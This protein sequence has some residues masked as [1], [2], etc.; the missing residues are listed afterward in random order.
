MGKIFDWIDNKFSIKQHHKKLFYRAL[1]DNVNYFYC[2]GGIA[3]TLYVS[4]LFTG[5]L[6]SV[7]YV[8]SEEEAF[9]SIVKITK[10]VRLGWFI[11]SLHKWGANLLIFFVILHTIRVI[12]HR[13]YKHPR[14]LNWVIGVFILI[15]IFAS[16]FTG[17]LLPWD[18]KAYWATV[19]GTSMV[20][21]V[22]IIGKHL[23][24]LLRGGTDVNGNTL[25]RFYSIH[26]L[27][28]PFITFLLLW[29]HFHIVKRYGI[30]G[31]L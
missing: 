12:I 17:Y 26:I 25:V 9:Q 23:L 24:Y 30:S 15:L 4:L 3:F 21:T 20:G 10:Q 8:P 29:T 5:I 1:P 27:W 7:Y 19:V 13:A 16:G 2:F 18:Q 6:L 28:L 31:N 11:R 14:E 22:P